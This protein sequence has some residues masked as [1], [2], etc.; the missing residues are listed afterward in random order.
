ML[1]T[2]IL[3]SVPTPISAFIVKCV[4]YEIDRLHA[5]LFERV[6]ELEKQLASTPKATPPQ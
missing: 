5:L 1:I 4:K 2:E 3:S 6:E